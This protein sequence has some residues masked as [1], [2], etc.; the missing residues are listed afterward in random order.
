V[1][2]DGHTL[3]VVPLPTDARFVRDDG[4]G[5]VTIVVVERRAQGPRSHAGIRRS[6]LTEV[7]IHEPVL[8]VINPAHASPHSLEIILFL[9]LRGVLQKGNSSSLADIVIPDA[10]S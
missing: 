4:K 5:S 2:A 8:F 3:T 7:E 1:V 6:R 9:G 10:H